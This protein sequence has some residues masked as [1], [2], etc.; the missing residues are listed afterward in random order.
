MQILS[1]AVDKEVEEGERSELAIFV[2]CLG[3]GTHGLRICRGVGEKVERD[4]I[5]VY[6]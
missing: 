5:T 4:T 2:L 3:Q 6:L 1:A